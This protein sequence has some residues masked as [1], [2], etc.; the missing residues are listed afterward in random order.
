MVRGQFLFRLS[1]L[2]AVICTAVASYTIK[3]T[4][5]LSAVAAVLLAVVLGVSC[6][7]LLLALFA[8]IGW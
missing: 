2:T 6:W 1:V 8:K 4:T 3:S 7:I 5:S